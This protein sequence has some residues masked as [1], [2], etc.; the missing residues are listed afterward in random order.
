MIEDKSDKWEKEYR[1]ELPNYQKFEQTLRIL[2]ETLLKKEGLSVQVSSRTKSP[3]S[4]REKI[5][6]KFKEGKSYDNPLNDTTDIV[7]IRIIAYY[8]SDIDKISY[9]IKREFNID[10]KNSLDKS[11]L[12][13]IDQ[14]GYK[15]VH[16]IVSLSEPRL[17]LTE[18]MEF[19]NYKAEIQIR[20]ILQHAW[21]EIDHEIRY[22][23][24]ENVPLEIKRRVYRLM[25]L[26]ELADEEFQNL[27]YD[28]DEL[29]GK[30]LKDITWGNFKLKLNA[31]SLSAYFSFTKQEEK[32]MKIS[33]KIIQEILC[34]YKT[35]K[36]ITIYFQIQKHFYNY[37]SISDLE[38]LL[39]RLEI[40]DLAEFDTIL[41]EADQY[42]K[43]ALKQTYKAFLDN[44]IDL[45]QDGSYDYE[46]NAYVNIS[47]LVCHKKE[48]LIR[49]NPSILDDIDYLWIVKEAWKI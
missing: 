20:T 13:G 26:F 3:S 11:A 1:S 32:W 27:K 9:I 14:F 12:L 4:F 39:S 46:F 5:E 41:R 29:K 44:L 48:E 24:E 45:T 19:S 34:T 2:I 22:K 43:D 18:W 23:K 30:Y 37:Q 38:R 10:R 49:K 8:L 28:T 25:A 40:K 16:Y 31:L 35:N 7:G 15:S 17:E 21:A 47:I 33:N 6:R 42:G 36:H